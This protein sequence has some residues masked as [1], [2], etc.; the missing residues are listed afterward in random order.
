MGSVVLVLTVKQYPA[1]TLLLENINVSFSHD[2]D[3]I[4]ESEP[5][6]VARLGGAT[7]RTETGNK[8]N[9]NF[10][11]K[12]ELKYADEEQLVIEMWDE[13]LTNDEKN[14]DETIKLSDLKAKGDYTLKLAKEGLGKTAK[15][16][17]RYELKGAVQNMGDTGRKMSERKMAP[18]PV[19]P[20]KEEE[21]QSAR[22]GGE[23]KKTERGREVA[24]SEEKGGNEE[25]RYHSNQNEIS[26][27]NQT[28]N[29]PSIISSNNQYGD[30]T[31]LL[32]QASSTSR[33]QPPSSAP[34]WST[35]CQRRLVSEQTPNIPG[36]LPTASIHVSGRIHPRGRGL[37][38]GGRSNSRTG[39]NAI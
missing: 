16:T 7:A 4:G 6:L 34:S 39:W 18:A 2:S 19:A 11:R 30:R 31:S 10:K 26:R 13:D 20:R 22:D 23:K 33:A 12:L 1:K 32:T 8:N 15:L 25:S 17:F 5:Y 35:P 36:S 24:K 3:L 21:L 38:L 37:V 27:N 28:I 29:L 9:T 14:F